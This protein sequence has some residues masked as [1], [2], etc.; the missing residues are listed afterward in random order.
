MNLLSPDL[1][2]L[3]IARYDYQAG[4]RLPLHAHEDYFQ[5]ILILHG[6]GTVLVDQHRLPFKKDQLFFFPPGRAHGLETAARGAVKTLDTKFFIRKANLKAACQNVPAVHPLSGPRI[7]TLFEA[8]Y[9][10]ARRHQPYSIELCRVLL[11]ELVLLLLANE[12]P[13]NHAQEI[14]PP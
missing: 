6:E 9:G 8:I 1:E 13:A 4:W 11:L 7:I 10:E 5:A 2:P 3:W 12:S 14:V